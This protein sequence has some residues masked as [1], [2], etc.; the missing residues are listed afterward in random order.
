MPF[1]QVITIYKEREQPLFLPSNKLKHQSLKV[2]PITYHAHNTYILGTIAAHEPIIHI[3]AN[4]KGH[5]TKNY[6]KDR[7]MGAINEREE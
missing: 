4:K 6:Q 5:Y 2:D 3:K 7:L 1:K